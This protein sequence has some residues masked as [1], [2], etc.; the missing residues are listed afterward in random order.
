MTTCI[1]TITKQT[2][3][4]C[5]ARTN[6][7]MR[8]KTGGKREENRRQ[9]GDKGRQKG[10]KREAKGRQREAKGRQKGGNAR[11]VP[12][13][14]IEN[15]KRRLVEALHAFAEVFSQCSDRKH[16]PRACN[17]VDCRTCPQLRASDLT[18]RARDRVRAALESC[19][20]FRAGTT[21]RA[22]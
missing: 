21:A 18:Q 8:E 14:C 2:R 1:P 12:R 16:L 19:L 6:R 7:N 11:C 22:Q 10:G 15:G 4:N 3:M 9:K 5:G 13:V 20:Q 17:G